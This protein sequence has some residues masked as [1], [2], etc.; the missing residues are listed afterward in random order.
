MRWLDGITNQHNGHEFYQT[1]GDSE[2][3]GSLVCYR[4]W[5]HRVEHGLAIEQQQLWIVLSEHGDA[6]PFRWEK[7]SPNHISDKGLVS[8]IRKKKYIFT[9]LQLR[10]KN[11]TSDPIKKCTIDLNR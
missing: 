2:G 11:K 4:S 1:P 6:I 10:S 9:I 8:K 5:G 3:Q 7:I